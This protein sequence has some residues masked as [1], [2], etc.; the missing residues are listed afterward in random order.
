[1]QKFRNPEPSLKLQVFCW[2]WLSI[3]NFLVCYCSRQKM[4]YGWHRFSCSSC[5]FWAL[6]S[7]FFVYSLSWQKS[8]SWKGQFAPLLNT[9]NC[10][11][12]DHSRC[13]NFLPH[14]PV[15]FER[16]PSYQIWPWTKLM[17]LPPSRTDYPIETGSFLA[18]RTCS[19]D[20]LSSLVMKLENSF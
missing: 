7:V 19:V 4:V 11:S 8:Y 2:K 18:A 13:S 5:I 9:F 10:P 16:R 15:L 1:M 17:H 12:F 3:T 20:F 6:V 14:N